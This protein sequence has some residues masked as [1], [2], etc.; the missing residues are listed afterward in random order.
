[1]SR[2]PSF[3]DQIEDAVTQA[4]NGTSRR[5]DSSVYIQWLCT[6]GELREASTAFGLIS[7]DEMLMLLANPDTSPQSCRDIG[8]EIRRRFTDAHL[9]GITDDAAERARLE[10]A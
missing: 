1:M 6:S 7:T 2:R 9:E 3:V 8:N 4:I 5:F 10:A